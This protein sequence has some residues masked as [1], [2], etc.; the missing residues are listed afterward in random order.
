[1]RFTR[2][3]GLGLLI[4]L[5]ASGSALAQ[6][7]QISPKT[8][9]QL[10]GTITQITPTEVEIDARGGVKKVA[11]NEIEVVSFTEEPPDMKTARSRALAGQVE[12]A[13][14]MLNRIPAESVSSDPVKADLEF[15]RAYC[16]AKISL[17][18]GGNKAAAA[19]ALIDFVNARPQNFHYF[20]ACELIGDVAFAMGRFGSAIDYYQRLGKAPWPEYQMRAKVLEARALLAEGK[21][22]DALQRYDEVLAMPLDSAAATREKLFAQIG[23]AVCEA[24]TGNPDQAKTTIETIIRDNDPQDAVLFARAYNALGL[25]NLKAQR[26]KDALLAYLHVDL[27]FNSDS[28]AHA[29]SLY[30]LGQLWAEVGQS[31]RAVD[32]RSLLKSRYA[33]TPWASK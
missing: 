25:A 14:A 6:R 8:G 3:A 29:E 20:E 9:P 23:R 19:K 21:H 13:L 33:G 26:P 16:M 1:M 15:Y 27:L 2:D 22:S 18:G 7:D 10:T 5:L 28:D 32:A 31:E 30:Y 11:V 12:E 4:V 17:S 24:E